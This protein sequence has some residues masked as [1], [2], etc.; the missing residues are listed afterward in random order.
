LGFTGLA[1]T[2][3]CLSAVPGTPQEM[4]ATATYE[5]RADG[6]LPLVPRTTTADYSLMQPE[7]KV[8]EKLC[9]T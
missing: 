8:L 5:V 9:A 2:S 3:T 1:G 4:F 7:R 6:D